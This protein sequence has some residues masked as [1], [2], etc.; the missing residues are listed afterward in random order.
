[1]KIAYWKELQF[2]IAPDVYEPAEDTFFIAENMSIGAGEKVLE[3]GTGC[4]ML[5]VLAAKAGGKVIATDINP[6][7]LECARANA[8][9]NGVKIDFRLGDLFEPVKGELFDQILFNP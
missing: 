5:A 3:L 9:A 8:A 7:A 2:L 1:M 6:T 4:G